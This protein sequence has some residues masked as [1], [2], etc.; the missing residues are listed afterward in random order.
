MTTLAFWVLNVTYFFQVHD[1]EWD[2]IHI[3]QSNVINHNSYPD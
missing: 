2:I 3:I 1:E